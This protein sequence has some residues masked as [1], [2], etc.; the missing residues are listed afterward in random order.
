VGRGGQPR[1][2]SPRT[3][4]RAEVRG[5]REQRA[6]GGDQLPEPD[7]RGPRR[8]DVR[9]VLQPA[10]DPLVR[11]RRALRIRVPRARGGRARGVQPPP[12]QPVLRPARG[13]RRQPGE[14]HELAAVAAGRPASPV[15]R[16]R[17]RG[18]PV[19][20]APGGHREGEAGVGGRGHRR[21]PGVPGRVARH[22]PDRAGHRALR[23]RRGG[24][25]RAAR[26]RDRLREDVPAAAVQPEGAGRDGRARPGLAVLRQDREGRCRG[27]PRPGRLPPGTS[28]SW[29]PSSRSTAET[30]A[31]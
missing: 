5:R 16:V 11:G 23:R 21:L 8:P 20:P 29:P 1:G 22:Q 17:D 10:H 4:G 15:G 19:H 6:A 25:G 13:G 12:P 26:R 31:R 9:P 24:P 18:R 27:D 14:L 3:K 28:T 2:R 7:L 30:P